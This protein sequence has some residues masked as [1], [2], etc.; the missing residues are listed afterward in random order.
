[1]LD[2]LGDIEDMLAGLRIVDKNGTALAYAS[3]GLA[4]AITRLPDLL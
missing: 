3:V 2:W 4:A 1:M